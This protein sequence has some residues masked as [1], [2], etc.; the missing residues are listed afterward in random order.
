[1]QTQIHKSRVESLARTLGFDNAFVVSS[2]CR[3]G[4]L[5]IFWNN[6]IK[7]DLLP[8]SQYHI[9]DV[10]FPPD[11]DPWWLTCVYGEAEV[12]ERHKT[13]DMLKFIK[14]S[15]PLPW[16]CIGDFNEVLLREEH[17][18]VNERSNT[19]IQAFRDTVDI[20][21][22]MDLATRVRRGLLKKKLREEPTAGCGLTML[23]PQRTGAQGSPLQP[24]NILLRQRRITH[25]SF[26]AMLHQI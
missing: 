25:R 20:C 23:W 22:L 15:S 24:R 18:G 1:V 8:Y 16:M 10:V 17:M 19:R 21:E 11:S 14:A 6:E 9:D 3:S 5:A 2:S 4:G 26:S 7:I 13:W 12:N